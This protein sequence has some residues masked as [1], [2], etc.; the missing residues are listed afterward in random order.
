MSNKI[1]CI[2]RKRLV[3]ATPEELVRQK[4]ISTMIASLG[5]P[6][7][8]L[9]LE[10]GLSQMPHLNLSNKRIPRRR[11]DLICFAKDIHPAHSIYPLLL[12]ECKAI[13]LSSK[14]VNQVAGYNHFLQAHFIAIANDSEIQTGWYDPSKNDYTFINFLPSYQ[15]LLKSVI[16]SNG[17]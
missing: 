1:S 10:K 12:I 5:Y 7:H 11:A 8:G 4:L 14:V 16:P 9:V 17:A 15:Q 6:P 13:K 3:S 2:I